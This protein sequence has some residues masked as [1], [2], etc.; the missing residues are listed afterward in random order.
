MLSDAQISDYG[1]ED[2]LGWS[3]L[4]DTSMMYQQGSSVEQMGTI[5]VPTVSIILHL[6]KEERKKE[7]E[8]KEEKEKEMKNEEK[9]E[10]EEERKKEMEKKKEE[11]ETKKNLRHRAVVK[12]GPQEI[13]LA[14]AFLLEHEGWSPGGGRLRRRKF[15]GNARK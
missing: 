5:P 9:K 2:A 7:M 13:D 11:E 3:P 8:K 15:G 6:G 4:V 12:S 1:P 14:F 10:K